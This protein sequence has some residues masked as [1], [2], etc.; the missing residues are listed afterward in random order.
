MP[1]AP[2]WPP[3][4]YGQSE[5]LGSDHERLRAMREQAAMANADS[6]ERVRSFAAH[7]EAIDAQ[8]RTQVDRVQSRRDLDDLIRPFRE[9]DPAG[10]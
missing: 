6:E 9:Q 8:I 7:E 3:T 5:T 1:E 10:T 4:T 2:T